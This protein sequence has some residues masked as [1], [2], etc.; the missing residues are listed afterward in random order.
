MTD[1]S[2]SLESRTKLNNGLSMPS[3]HLGVYLMNGSE[4][5]TAVKHALE[6]GYR[7]VDSAQMYR[8]EK[9]VGKS[10]LDY[11]KAHPEIKR[12]D[13][14]YTTKLASNSDYARAR[15]SISQ[16]VKEC[17]LGYIDL[18]L[19]HSPYGGKQARLDS[20][21]AVEDAI[22]DGEVKTGGVSNYGEK[23]LDEL[24]ASSPRIKPA[25]N[26]IEVHPFNT[27][28]NL[29][30]YCQQHDIVVEAYAPLARALRMKHPTIVSLAKK[31]GCTSG[32]LMVRWSLQH[33]YV[34]LP[35]SVRKERIIENSQ[36]G[37]FEISAE[38]VKAMDGLDEYLVTDWDPVDAD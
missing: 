24:F 26:Q 13:I 11:L 10:I 29:T 20:W 9:Q 1:Q 27:R 15:R 5:S 17:G 37:G 30:A 8:N 33:G 2:Y 14:H 31:Y 19:L 4:A 12:E 3:I 16:S 35:K 23:H 25:V 32:Q 38:D 18:F 22:K 34:P 28:S 6:A 21:R 7:A 36:V